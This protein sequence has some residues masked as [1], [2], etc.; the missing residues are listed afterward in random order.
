MLRLLE[1][2]FIPERLVNIGASE[3]PESFYKSQEMQLVV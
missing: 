3:W 2:G 1:D